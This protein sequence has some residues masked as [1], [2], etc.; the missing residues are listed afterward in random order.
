MPIRVRHKQFP[1]GAL[2]IGAKTDLINAEQ[3]TRGILM[4]EGVGS[5]G[6]VNASPTGNIAQI[7]TLVRTNGARVQ[8]TLVAAKEAYVIA[9]MPKYFRLAV[10]TANM[11]DANMT[12]IREVA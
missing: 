2:A 3:F 12:G 1:L 10:A 4:L 8:H 7:Y 11:L 6:T 5:R 9:V